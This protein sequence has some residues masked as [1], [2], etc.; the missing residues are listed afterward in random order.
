MTVVSKDDALTVSSN[1]NVNISEVRLKRV[2]S[3]SLGLVS[4]G[5]YVV[6]C[7]ASFGSLGTTRLPFISS[8][9]VLGNDK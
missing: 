3:T 1:S 6:T 9:V 2:N 5:V 7:I 8:I 4:S